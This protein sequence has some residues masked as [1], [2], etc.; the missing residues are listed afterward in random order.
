MRKQMIL[1]HMFT[2]QRATHGTSLNPSCFLSQGNAD[3]LADMSTSKTDAR[4]EGIDYLKILNGPPQDLC[5]QLT[6]LPHFALYVT[7]HLISESSPGKQYKGT[8]VMS[9]IWSSFY[10]TVVHKTVN[11]YVS[12][13][14]GGDET[15]LGNPCPC[16][17]TI[18]CIPVQICRCMLT[19]WTLRSFKVPV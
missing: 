6:R 2:S 3:P 17:W 18:S 15:I 16:G 7:R 8:S 1:E 4:Q 9:A 12:M 5:D 11:I 19:L 10:S 14:S 13:T